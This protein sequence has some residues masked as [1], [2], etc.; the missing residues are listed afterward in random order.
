MQFY[1]TSPNIFYSNRN[2]SPHIITCTFLIFLPSCCAHSHWLSQACYSCPALLC[3]CWCAQSL[4]SCLSLCNP[5][6]CSPPGSS[7]YGILQ[8]RILEWVAISLVT[9]LEVG[10]ESGGARFSTCWKWSKLRRRSPRQNPSTGNPGL[11]SGVRGGDLALW[12]HQEGGALPIPG[13]QSQR[14]SL[15]LAGE[16]LREGEKRNDQV[17]RKH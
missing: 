1:S 8:A 12:C 10:R 9:I 3:M 5:M 16:K 11:R 7:V 17:R 6:D 15:W 4:Q 2:A 13:L 14:A